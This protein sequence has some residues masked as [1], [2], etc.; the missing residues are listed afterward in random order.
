MYVTHEQR[1]RDRQDSFNRVQERL[2]T[3][4]PSFE[5]ESEEKVLNQLEHFDGWTLIDGRSLFEEDGKFPPSQGFTLVAASVLFE[6]LMGGQGL[7]TN[8]RPPDD[9][10]SSRVRLLRSAVGEPSCDVS[11]W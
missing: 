3:F 9:S 6:E 2:R 1:T 7:G 10:R 4:N 5:A 11:P 8:V